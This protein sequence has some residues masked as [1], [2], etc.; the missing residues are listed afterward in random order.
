MARVDLKCPMCGST[1]FYVK[2]WRYRHTLQESAPYG[3]C[4]KCKW[5]GF[6]QVKEED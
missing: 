3:K 5:K 4:P 2:D 1:S 6:L